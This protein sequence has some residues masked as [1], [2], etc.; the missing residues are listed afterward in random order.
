LLLFLLLLDDI[1]VACLA[2]L[3]AKV[4]AGL[5]LFG[6]LRFAFLATAGSDALLKDFLWR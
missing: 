1:V 4:H 2:L 6:D 3:H 5:L